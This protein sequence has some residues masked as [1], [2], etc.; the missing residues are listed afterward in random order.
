MQA[1]RGVLPLMNCQEARESFPVLLEESLGLTDRVPLE[2]H[3]NT[4]EGCQ[5][6]LA[7]LQELKELKELEQRAR[8]APRPIHWRPILAPG[9][10]KKALGVMRVEDVTTRLR[11]LVAEKVRSRQ[12][13]VAA[14]V[15][16]VVML[17][18]FVFERGFT[19]GSATPQRPVA[20]PAETRREAS[21]GAPVASVA[22]SPLRSQ[23]TT[24][25]PA[26]GAPPAD[27]PIGL[28]RVS[29]YKPIPELRDIHF[30]FGAAAIR[31]GNL[32]ILDANAAWLRAHPR[33]L[34]LIEGHC[35]N[36]GATS[37]KNEFNIDLGEQ[38]AQA[39]MKH[40][41]AQGLHARRIR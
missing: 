33:L 4:C 23:A 29:D 3:V 38:R 39:A 11:R 27:Q 30:D 28:P 22:P 25:P 20:A 2:L 1:K 35:D 13:A 31:P 18:V 6:Q 34:L 21:V 32:K 36:R 12:L 8:P 14:A 37:R 19:V 40:L 7:H 41:V 5:R 15:S 24:M 16:L 17:A 9:L 10:V 26:S